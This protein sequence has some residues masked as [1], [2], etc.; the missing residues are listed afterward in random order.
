ML[1]KGYES[2]YLD[3]YEFYYDADCEVSSWL[4]IFCSSNTDRQLKVSVCIARAYTLRESLYV[5][6]FLTEPLPVMWRY[7]A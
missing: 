7:I 6:I 5:V 2:D 1:S 4:I 3:K